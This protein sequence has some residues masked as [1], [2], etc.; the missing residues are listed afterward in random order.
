[1]ST[2]LVARFVSRLRDV[3]EMHARDCGDRAVGVVL[4]PDD[5]ER[6]RVAEVWGVPVLA[7]DGVACGRLEVLCDARGVLVPEFHTFEDV[8]QQ[9]KYHP[10]LTHSARA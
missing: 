2:L 5:H 6:L 9:W 4:H 3:L 10:S 8:V 7:S 1:M